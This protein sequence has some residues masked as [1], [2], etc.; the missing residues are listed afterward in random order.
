MGIITIHSLFDDLLQIIRASLSLLETT[1]SVFSCPLLA[2]PGADSHGC[3]GEPC[4]ARKCV[5]GP[6]PLARAAKQMLCLQPLKLGTRI[7]GKIYVQTF[8][9]SNLR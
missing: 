7:L 6:Y 1:F 9:N 4:D 3:H 2:S 5:L 8:T